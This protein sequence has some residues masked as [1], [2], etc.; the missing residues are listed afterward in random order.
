MVVNFQNSNGSSVP[1]VNEKSSWSV[2]KI[3]KIFAVVVLFVI[4]MAT[5]GAF[6]SS[7]SSIAPVAAPEGGTFIHEK[8]R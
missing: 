3:F 1:F 2:A 4:T 7:K 8:C 6:V 5:F